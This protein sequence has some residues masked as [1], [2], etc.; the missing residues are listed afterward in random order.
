MSGHDGEI[1]E[2]FE[3]WI[4]AECSCGWSQG[5]FVARDDALTA[6]VEHAGEDR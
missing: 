2:D 5:P 1:T 4:T 6:L 3:G